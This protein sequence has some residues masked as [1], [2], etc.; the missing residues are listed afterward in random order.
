MSTPQ[1]IDLDML[2]CSEY[3]MA[4]QL[5]ALLVEVL[6]ETRGGAPDLAV[7]H[8]GDMV[9]DYGCGLATTR[10]VSS[11][12]VTPARTSCT[13]DEHRVTIELRMVRCYTTPP[14]NAMPPVS[15]LD[16]ATRD[17]LDDA[18][19]MRAAIAEFRELTGL[20]VTTGAWRPHGPKGGIHGGTMTVQILTE[21]GQVSPDTVPTLPG[22]PRGITL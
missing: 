9:P 14:E 7:V 3:L 16:S 11:D 5:L 1:Q 17:A 18:R 20:R 19:A 12:V 22:D 21:L 13:V 2:G 15:V 8:P 6:G 4:G 10:V